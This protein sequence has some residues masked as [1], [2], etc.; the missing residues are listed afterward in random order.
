MVNT[1]LDGFEHLL[2]VIGWDNG[3]FMLLDQELETR[4]GITSG[5]TH[6]PPLFI[7]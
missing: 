1:C 7:V 6:L 2:T 5:G 4:R 3:D